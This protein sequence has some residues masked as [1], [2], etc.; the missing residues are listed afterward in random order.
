MS[1]GDFIR[2]G[3]NILRL[4]DSDITIVR[5]PWSWGAAYCVWN[6]DKYIDRCADGETAKAT[7]KSL[8]T[9]QKNA[10]GR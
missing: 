6:G 7:A 2:T 9:E 3:T 4:G 1:A 10:H 5:W 8:Y